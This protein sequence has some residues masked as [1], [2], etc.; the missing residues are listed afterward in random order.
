MNKHPLIWISRQIR[1]RIPGLIVMTAAQV[2]HA[3]FGVLFALGFRNVIDSAAA[4]VTRLA[5]A[6][7]VL[8]ALDLRFTILIAASGVV[9]F[10][11]TVLLWHRLKTLNKLVSE[12]DGKVSGFLQEAME[13][14][15][16]IQTLDVSGEM[17]RRADLL[18]GERYEIQRKRKNMSLL[19]NTGL[20]LMAYGASFFALVWCARRMLLGQMTFGSLTAVIQLVGQFIGKAVFIFRTVLYNPDMA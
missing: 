8:G 5:A 1:N 14:L 15:L 17:E 19:T 4:M 3:F 18:M 7:A 9:I 20:N 2:G 6:V 11:A 12:H 10:T 13:K 16:M